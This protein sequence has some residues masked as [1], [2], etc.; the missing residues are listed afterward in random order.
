MLTYVFTQCTVC[1]SVAR[2]FPSRELQNSSEKTRILQNKP[3][4]KY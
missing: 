1:I 3:H 4:P 2:P